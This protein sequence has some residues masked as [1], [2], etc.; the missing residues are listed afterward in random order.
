[1]RADLGEP[2]HIKFFGLG[3]IA[4]G[5]GDVV[6]A[7]SLFEQFLADEHAAFNRDPVVAWGHYGLGSYYLMADDPAEAYVRFETSLAIFRAAGIA[8]AAIDTLQKLGLAAQAQGA[9]DHAIAHFRESMELA[10]ARRYRR[11]VALCLFG[12]AGIALKQGELEPAARLF[13][14]AEALREMTSGMDADQ[15]YVTDR[16]IARL[17]ERLDPTTLE[18]RWA[19]G[20]ALDWEQAVE[21]ALAFA[22]TV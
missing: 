14:A 7:G 11:M 22:T 12:F 20:R 2:P 3:Y 10:R 13:G 4:L 9:L 5:E 21:E 15:H 1:M 18:A 8:L 16:E 6:A 17:R 19:E